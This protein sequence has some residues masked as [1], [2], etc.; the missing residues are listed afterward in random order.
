MM[1]VYSVCI[2]RHD[3]ERGAEGEGGKG[4]GNGLLKG[5]GTEVRKAVSFKRGGGGVRV[6]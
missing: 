1:S 6:Y 2:M 5:G 3:G 4:G